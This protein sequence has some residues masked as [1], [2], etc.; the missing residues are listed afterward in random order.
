[1]LYN[2][3]SIA[4]LMLLA[5]VCLGVFA[6]TL[7][8]NRHVDDSMPSTLNKKVESHVQTYVEFHDL[9]DAKTDAIRQVLR[10]HRHKVREM[11]L[12]LA[13]DHREQFTAQVK[14]TEERIQ[15]V[16]EGR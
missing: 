14:L 12:D 5:G 7:V 16:L 2:L 4:L 6:G 13:R 3:R 10:A 8:A 11:L 9:D 15:S 1:M